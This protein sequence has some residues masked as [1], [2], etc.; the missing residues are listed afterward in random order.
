VEIII[1]KIVHFYDQHL[2]IEE[3]EKNILKYGV[4][5]VVSTVVAYIVAL[6]IA[7]P[8]GILPYVLVMML[9]MSILRNFSGGGHCSS[10][11]NCTLYGTIVVI[12]MG[13]LYDLWKPTKNMGFVFSFGVFLFSLWAIGQYAPADTPEKPIKSEK[14]KKRLRRQSILIITIWYGCLTA[15]YYGFTE[16]NPLIYATAFGVL[17]Q[18]FSITPI[19]YFFCHQTD[20]IINKLLGR[21]EKVC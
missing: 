14:K 6:L 12:G 16:I 20:W 4:S 7:W 21:R 15:I 2:H 18:S 13:I 9:S 11:R 5:V 10:I 1:D 3:S 19:G 17:W 8:L